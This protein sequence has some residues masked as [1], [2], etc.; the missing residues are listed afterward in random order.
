MSLNQTER[1]WRALADPTRRA[2]L[3]VLAERARTTGELTAQFGGL[4]RTTVMKHMDVLT[5]AGLLVV[6]RDGRVRW[7]HLNAAPIQNVCDRWVA[8]HVRHLSG[9][10]SRLKQ[11]LESPKE[12]PMSKRTFETS[13]AAYELSI[14][15]EASSQSVW[16]AIASNT[17]AWWL[18]DFHMVGADSVVEFRA[19]A[20]GQLIEK[21]EG[22][23]SLLWYTVHMV[24]PGRTVQ[25]VGQSFPGWGG[26]G[27]S[28]LKL[29]LEANDDDSV[30]TLQVSDS[31]FGKCS[32]EHIDSL[33]EGWTVLFRDGLKKYVETNKAN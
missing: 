30:T 26:P 28:M 32:D 20:G 12:K 21:I 24:D 3:D 1:V 22:G 16:H 6:K 31:V 25:M 5:R 11:S 15:I 2:I 4:S 7:N 18:P 33:I 17:N 27:T 14:E 19:E 13:G 23:G 8:K 29:S 9:A 10:L